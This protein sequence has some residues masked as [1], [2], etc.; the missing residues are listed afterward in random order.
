MIFGIGIYMCTFVFFF[1][2]D[3]FS[4]GE[5][6]DDFV[7]TSIIEAGDIIGGYHVLAILG[8]YMFI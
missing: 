1:D 7:V 5:D 3:L 4:V 8:Q 6:T 2:A